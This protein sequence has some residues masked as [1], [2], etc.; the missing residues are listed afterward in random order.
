MMERQR[1]L[2]C[3]LGLLIMT[4]VVHA[5]SFTMRTVAVTGSASLHPALASSETH[6][7]EFGS[8]PTDAIV[9]DHVAENRESF[10]DG[11]P[12]ISASSA[13]LVSSN[14]ELTLSFDGLRII[15]SRHADGG[16][17]FATEPPDQGLCAGNGY[18]LESVNNAIRVYS[19]NGNALSEVTSHNSFYGYPVAFN[20]TTGAFGP[21]ISDPVCH[22]DS[23]M[24]R[25]FHVVITFDRVGTTSAL[26]GPNHLD[27]AVS[28]TSS[29]LGAWNIYRIP[30]QNDG[31]QGTP[32]HHCSG[33][34]C[35][36][37]YPKI[38]AD[39]YGIY[40]T[41]NEYPLFG[42][43]SRGAQIYAISKRV[44]AAGGPVTVAQFDTS[45]PSLLLDG[46]P[47][48]GVWPATAPSLANA[49]DLGGTEYFLSA[50][51]FFDSGRSVQ[52]VPSTDNRLRI[53]ALSNT[54]SLDSS[55]PALALRHGVV[56]VES[57]SFPPPAN[58][59]E[60]NVPLADC[61]NDAD[62]ET[63]FGTGCWT[64]LFLNK[65][66]GNEREAQH[67]AH[68]FAMQQVVYADG[69]L[70]SALGTALRLGNK[71]QAGIAYFIIRPQ[72]STIG[73]AGQVVKQGNLG[74]A[75]NNLTYPAVGVTS[76]GRGVIA[77][78]LLGDDH[79]PSAAYATLDAVTGAGEIH[80]ASEG[81]GPEDG[82]TGYKAY[83]GYAGYPRW[84]DYGA[85]A[86]DGNSI[87]IA[88][89]YIGQTCTFAE[90]VAGISAGATC[91]GTR[92][93]VGNWYTRISK[94]TP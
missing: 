2:V 38:G 19:S 3:V 87:W 32:D 51:N 91:G 20:R 35:Y 54:Q 18:V 50:I 45:D 88:S 74:L 79:F 61:L 14:P 43:P 78:T 47:G 22:Y 27:L 80:V 67:V 7:P 46:N 56:D 69:Q 89:E 16:N 76:S 63:P 34:P 21:F 85:T 52:V 29:P 42:G 11:G 66:P 39:A 72:V 36:A 41:S 84:G 86:I 9:H 17:A 62:L 73:V 8:N 65:P 44:L 59:K 60:G 93:I 82:W 10:T 30:T 94:I 49:L 5:Q 24:Q 64:L 75:G 92:S 68:T 53:W 13:T 81:L 58:Q 37:D 31:T 26:A 1:V 48:F 15:D 71:T 6:S 4:T 57:Y 83:V 33:G 23:D 40:I 12:G 70:W 28:Q 77:F 90:Y 55:S 25:W